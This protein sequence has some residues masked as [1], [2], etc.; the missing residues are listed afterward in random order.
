MKKKS[1]VPDPFYLINHMLGFILDI[2]QKCRERQVE[3]VVENIHYEG[4]GNYELCIDDNLIAS[5]DIKTSKIIMY[6]SPKFDATTN[7]YIGK[8]LALME[9][10]HMLRL[11]NLCNDPI[12]SDEDEADHVID[13]LEGWDYDKKCE[14]EVCTI[15]YNDGYKELMSW[16]KIERNR[17]KLKNSHGGIFT[18]HMSNVIDDYEY[19]ANRMVWKRKKK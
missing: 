19:G 3:L 15:F 10:I 5:L 9:M 18:C 17:S 7:I 1:S 6:K 14:A 8:A 4:K 16:D 2:E 11:V 13:D 12:S